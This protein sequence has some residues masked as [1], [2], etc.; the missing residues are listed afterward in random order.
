MGTLV[1][2]LYFERL[3]WSPG[4]PQLFAIGGTTGDEAATQYASVANDNFIGGY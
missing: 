4:V 2:K 3:A 1:L